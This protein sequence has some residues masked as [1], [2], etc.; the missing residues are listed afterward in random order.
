MPRTSRSK[1]EARLAARK[2]G[3]LAQLLFQAARLYN[4]RAIARVRRK[5]PEARVGHTRLFPY[6]D[7]AGTRLTELARR[8]GVTKQAVGQ[9]VDELEELGVVER[10][11]DPGDKRAQLVTFTEAGLAQ[12]VAGFDVLDGIE[13]ELQGE[14]GEPAMK[15]LEAGLAKVVAALSAKDEE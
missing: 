12:L 3:S 14:L 11:P 15:A 9:M 2:A 8:A 4:E 5:T 6:I 10:T 1:L 13:R 7:L